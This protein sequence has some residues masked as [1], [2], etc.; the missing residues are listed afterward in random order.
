LSKERNVKR[1]GFSPPR[2]AFCHHIKVANALRDPFEKH[3]ASNNPLAWHNSN[4]A[5]KDVSTG[6]VL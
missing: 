3:Q 1:S 5:Q 2:T 6:L 4:L